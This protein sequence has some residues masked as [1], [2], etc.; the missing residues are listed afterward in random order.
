MG[1]EPFFLIKNIQNLN[2]FIFLSK[3]DVLLL[4]SMCIFNVY[5]NMHIFKHFKEYLII[6][7]KRLIVHVIY[8]N[9]LI[10]HGIEVKRLKKVRKFF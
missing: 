10:I 9:V 3:L 4:S 2:L 6:D 1:F 5:K 7:V 8:L